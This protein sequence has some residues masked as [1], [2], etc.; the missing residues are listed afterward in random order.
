MRGSRHWFNQHAGA[1][2]V[3]ACGFWIDKPLSDDYTLWMSRVSCPKCQ[4]AVQAQLERLKPPPSTG[5]V[6]AALPLAAWL[7]PSRAGTIDVRS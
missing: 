6:I 1:W 4:I 3:A 2:P 7:Q 5:R